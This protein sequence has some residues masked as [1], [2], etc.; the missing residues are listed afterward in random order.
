MS[1]GI[2]KVEV[3]EV[4]WMQGSCLGSDKHRML[5]WG[6]TKGGEVWK[7]IGLGEDEAGGVAGSEAKCE[8]N[9]GEGLVDAVF[10]VVGERDAERG[11][12][13]RVVLVRGGKVGVIEGDGRN[14]G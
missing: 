2:I 12:E 8:T 5:S 10:E 7:G 4:L 11:E 14:V 9:E 1:R 6:K 3:R 13:D